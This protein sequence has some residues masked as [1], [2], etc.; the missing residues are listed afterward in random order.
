MATLAFVPA[1][2]AGVVPLLA[3]VVALGF[4]I[5]VIV[6]VYQAAIAEVVADDSH[7]LSY[8]FTYLGMFGVGALGA[9]VAGV[10]LTYS[11]TAALFAVLSV[12][13]AVA[14]GLAVYLWLR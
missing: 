11:G 1:S 2:N 6:P 3:V 14:G 7:G 13:A 9:S 12:F 10:V 4:L 8:G 5:Y